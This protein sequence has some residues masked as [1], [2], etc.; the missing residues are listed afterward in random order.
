MRG[1]NLHILFLAALVFVLLYLAGTLAAD[2]DW[3]N[4]FADVCSKTDAADTLSPEELALLIERCERLR[5][6]IEQL[7]GSARRVY[8]RRLRTCRD[9]YRFMLESKKKE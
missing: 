5:P 4:E 8:L 6:R 3:K 7:D 2:D 1:R 9:L